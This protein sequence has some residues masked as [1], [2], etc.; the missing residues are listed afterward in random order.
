MRRNDVRVRPQS[1]ATRV[2]EW[3]GLSAADLEECTHRPALAPGP[4]R[5]SAGHPATTSTETEDL[6]GGGPPAGRAGESDALGSGSRRRS[7]RLIRHS[8]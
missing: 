4:G 3:A 5:G 1:S 6:P 2:L 7:R 8:I